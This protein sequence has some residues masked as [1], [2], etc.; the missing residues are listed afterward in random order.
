MRLAIPLILN[1][2]LALAGPAS[3]ELPEGEQRAI[4]CAAI[5]IVVNGSVD[6]MV[7]NGADLDARIPRLTSQASEDLFF[8]AVP[9]MDAGTEGAAEMASQMSTLV[10]ARDASHQDGTFTEWFLQ[11]FDVVRMCHVAFLDRMEQAQ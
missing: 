11:A 9:F 4:E 6:G 2:S 7:A 10:A 3:A 8:D 5:S 1:G